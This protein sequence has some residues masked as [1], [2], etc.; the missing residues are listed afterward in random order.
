MH[1]SSFWPSDNF[2]GGT[3]GIGAAVVRDLAARKAQIILLTHHPP[4]DPFLVDY[5]EDLR[6]SSGNELIYV[7]EVDLSSLHSVR[8]FAT[9]WVDNAPPRRLDMI[10]LCADTLKPR[11][12][13]P[14]KT[15]DQLDPVWGINYLA[16]FHLLSIMSPA[17]RAQPPD[18]DVR[19]VF[20]TC[21]SYVG[22][23]LKALKDD[24]DPL[25]ADRRYET[26]KLATTV[27]AQAFQKHLDAH[28]RPDKQP[29]N[30]RV[31]VVDPGYTRTPGMRRWLTMGSLWGL[32]VYPITIP[33]W[34]LVLK[35]PLQ[36]A[37]GFLN[38]A[39]E[40]DLGRGPGG[41]LIKE[42]RE[43]IYTREEVKDESVQKKL[44]AFSEKQIEALEKEGA[45]RRA[46]AKKEAEVAS[47][48]ASA[49]SV[50]DTENVTQERKEKGAKQ[51]GSRRSRK[52]AL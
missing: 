2:K 6:N 8:E 44:W 46:L 40:A 48:E 23:N 52:A 15:K 17:I 7:E 47:K 35:S 9:K 36:G 37:Q 24:R 31:I 5:I 11:F 32:L 45:V 19:I 14:S 29:N 21:S 33:L 28:K 27:F 38:A 20:A 30:T 39:M 34:W 22:G 4:S 3:S 51:A 43:A 41:R 25:P 50:Q 42:C 18:R 26:S 49:K 1:T 10:V 16:N 13:I 12:G